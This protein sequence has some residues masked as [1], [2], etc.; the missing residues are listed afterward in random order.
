MAEERR[1]PW[2]FLKVDPKDLVVETF[3]VVLGI[4]LA[5]SV[6][7]FIDDRHA[8]TRMM[9]ALGEIR[10]EIAA[11]DVTIRAL[12][13][14]HVRV[15]ES[16]EKTLKAARGEQVDFDTFSRAFASAAPKGFQ[17][18]NGTTTAWELAR[19][20]NV[21][22]DVPYEVRKSLQERYSHIAGL[23]EQ[24]SGLVQRLDSSA[25]ELRPNFYFTMR[26]STLVLLDIGATED[27]LLKDDSEA[28][29]QLK[30]FGV[31]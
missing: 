23:R 22:S 28:L 6:G 30:H 27:E 9:D 16:F 29:D 8:H 24:N 1:S 4:I 25:S 20:G 7:R 26:A 14:L 11:D 18:F 21:L 10:Q 19:N 12:H 17:P 3:S 31:E 2:A 5:V 15:R 13:P